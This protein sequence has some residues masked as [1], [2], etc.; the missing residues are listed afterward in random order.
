MFEHTTDE[1]CWYSHWGDRDQLGK[2]STS[3]NFRC[4]HT[5]PLPSELKHS[6]HELHICTTRNNNKQVEKPRGKK[7]HK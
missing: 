5:D 1:V 4:M 3:D 7:Q 6:T 2:S